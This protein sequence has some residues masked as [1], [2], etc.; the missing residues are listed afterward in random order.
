MWFSW[1]WSQKSLKGIWVRTSRGAEQE[2]RDPLFTNPAWPKLQ[3]YPQPGLLT[4]V[5]PSCWDSRRMIGGCPGGAEEKLSQ[6][7]L[8]TGRRFQLRG[9][10]VLLRGLETSACGS[11]SNGRWCIDRKGEIDHFHVDCKYRELFSEAPFLTLVLISK[12]N[13]IFDEKVS[14]FSYLCIIYWEWCMI[15]H[16]PRRK[17]D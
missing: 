9:P 10:P 8:E 15:D 5:N 2:S 1:G 6:T 12:P 4:V 7:V 14:R 16:D 13:W 11:R 17:K 3:W